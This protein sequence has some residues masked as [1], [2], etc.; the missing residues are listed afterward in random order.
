[1]KFSQKVVLVC[2]VLFCVTILGLVAGKRLLYPP[3]VNDLDY[4]ASKISENDYMQNCLKRLGADEIRIFDII[5]IA[6]SISERQYRIVGFSIGDTTTFGYSLMEITDGKLKELRTHTTLPCSSYRNWEERPLYQDQFWLENDRYCDIF[7]SNSTQLG[8]ISWVYTNREKR[9][10]SEEF[11]VLVDETPFIYVFEVPDG[12]TGPYG[13][14]NG[15]KY[16][17][18]DH[19]GNQL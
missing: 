3:D 13:L 12:Y 8:R 11:E 6:P 7:I 18:W 5:D 1:M 2:S 10:E 9:I 14:Y 19:E 4:L 15:G 17:C 16:F